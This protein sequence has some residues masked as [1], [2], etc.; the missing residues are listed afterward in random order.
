MGCDQSDAE[1]NRLIDTDTNRDR[2]TDIETDT[3]TD[4]DTD[5]RNLWRSKTRIHVVKGARNQ[6][7]ESPGEPA[8]DSRAK[9]PSKAKPA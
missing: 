5:S 2:E 7:L 6:A 1:K 8:Q 3:D 9:R 4:Q